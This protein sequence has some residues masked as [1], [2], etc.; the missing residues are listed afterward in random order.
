MLVNSSI[1]DV[2]FRAFHIQ[3]WND[4]VRPMSMIEM[5]KHA[6]KMIIAYCL[7]KYEEMDG[8]KI[9]WQEMI[10]RGIYELMRRIV[11]SDIKSECLC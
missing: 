10:R 6:H 2:L 8:N 3:R 1:L 4:R 9:D 5:D 11:I 7:G